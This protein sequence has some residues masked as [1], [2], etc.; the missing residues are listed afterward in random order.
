[1]AE[2]L[3]TS[4]TDINNYYDTLADIQL[5]LTQGADWQ[6]F[7]ACRTQDPEIFFPTGTA[8]EA[9]LKDEAA[10][11]ICRS[12]F[13]KDKCLDGALV[14]DEQGIWAGT[15]EDERRTLHRLQ[16]RTA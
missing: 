10:R 7:A 11:A 12:C 3:Q 14:G 4:S 2:Q 5:Q 8:R 6:T 16:R 15:N 13:V 1:M 9:A